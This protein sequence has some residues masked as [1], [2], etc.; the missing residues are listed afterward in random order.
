MPPPYA[1]GSWPTT[2][3]HQN[4]S[5]IASVILGVIALVT[6][7]LLI[8]IFFGIAAVATGFV[9]RSRSTAGAVSPPGMAVVGIV[10]GAVA[11]VVGI[12][13][14]G[15]LVWLIVNVQTDPCFPVKH[16]TGCY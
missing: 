5:A 9:A 13:A 10:I 12:G 14:L 8:G 2:S 4:G 6:S 15:F 7:W 11:I 16:H 1:S 3:R